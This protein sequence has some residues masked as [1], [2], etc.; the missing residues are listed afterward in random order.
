MFFSPLI[1]TQSAL[2]KDLMLS[3]RGPDGIVNPLPISC[4]ELKHKIEKFFC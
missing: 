3:L 4:L 1:K 2:F